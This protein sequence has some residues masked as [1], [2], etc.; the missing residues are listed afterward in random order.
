MPRTLDRG[1]RGSSEDNVGLALEAAGNSVLADLNATPAPPA[2][3]TQ[4]APVPTA[5]ERLRQIADRHKEGLL[6]DEEFSAAKA[7]LLEQL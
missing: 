4:I 6:S 5:A 7:K 2:V 3:T 1:R